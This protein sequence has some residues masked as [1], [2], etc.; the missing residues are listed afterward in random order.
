MEF[1]HLKTNIQ[2]D[3]IGCCAQTDNRGKP[4]P[5]ITFKKKFSLSII[6]NPY[7]ASSC[8]VPS[9]RH[10]RSTIAS[11]ITAAGSLKIIVCGTC[12]STIHNFVRNNTL[13]LHA[14]IQAV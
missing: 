6:Q 13:T 12:L 3:I 11:T 9:L 1:A 4:R 14:R 10:P 7:I 8:D 5:F 2:Y